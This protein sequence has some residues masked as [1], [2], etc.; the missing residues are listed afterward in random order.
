MSH[1][2]L[3]TNFDGSRVMPEAVT[4]SWQ[5]LGSYMGLAPQLMNV[6]GGIVLLIIGYF[7]A[8]FVGSL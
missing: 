2:L 4:E 5:Q 6:L 3:Q 7:V 1:L 8:K